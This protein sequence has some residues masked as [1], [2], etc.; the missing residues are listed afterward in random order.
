[1]IELLQQRLSRYTIDGAEQQEQALKEMLQELTLYALWRKGF[2]QVAAFQRGTCLR[3]LYGLTGFPKI[4]I[5]FSRHPIRTFHG[6]ACLKALQRFL[7]TL[8]LLLS[9]WTGPEPIAW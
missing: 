3:I 9:W 2:F 7:L 4:W 8:V 5:L 1:M 6:Q